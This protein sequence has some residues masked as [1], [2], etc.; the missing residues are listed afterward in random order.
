MPVVNPVTPPPLP[1]FPDQGRSTPPR[2]PA[3]PIPHYRPVTPPI[4]IDQLLSHTQRATMRTAQDI[5]TILNPGCQC[6]DCKNHLVGMLDNLVRETMTD[7]NILLQALITFQY[8]VERLTTTLERP[9]LV[10]IFGRVRWAK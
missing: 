3:Q 10:R 1:I 9:F 8:T 5:F 6:D 7:Q 4:D 2:V